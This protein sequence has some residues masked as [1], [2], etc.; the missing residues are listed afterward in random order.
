MVVERR[1]RLFRKGRNQAVQIP[2]EFELPGR[3]AIIHKEGGRLVI[4]AAPPRSLL[5]LLATLEP[6]EDEVPVIEELPRRRVDL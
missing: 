6:I 3:E 1:V 5:A 2:R 4:E